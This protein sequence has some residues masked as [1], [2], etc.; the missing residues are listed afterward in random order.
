MVSAIV[1]QREGVDAYAAE[2]IGKEVGNRGFNRVMMKS[3]QEPAM[4]ALLQAV[5]N[6]RVQEIDTGKRLEMIPESPQLRIE[7][8]VDKSRATCRQCK[9]K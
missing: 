6:E 8:Q 2:P 9:D 4:R 1:D 5:K 7:G 3:D